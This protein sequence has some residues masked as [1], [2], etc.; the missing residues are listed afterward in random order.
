M[1]NTKIIYSI[2]IEIDLNISER[3]QSL[4]L[5]VPGF[6]VSV[7]VF[8]MCVYLIHKVMHLSSKAIARPFLIKHKLAP[9]SQEVPFWNPHMLPHIASRV[10]QGHI[11]RPDNHFSP[12]QLKSPYTQ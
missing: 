8:L 10:S 1:K 9:V 5:L 12:H 4:H 3:L 7:F 6:F 2:S 11:D